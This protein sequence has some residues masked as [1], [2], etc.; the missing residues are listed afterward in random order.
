MPAFQPATAGIWSNCP[1][2]RD[3]AYAL[4][5]QGDS[6][7]PLYRDG[8]VLI[9][10]PAATIKRGDRVV[11]RD[12]YGRGDG[13]GAVA[14]FGGQARSQPRSTRAHPMRT[15]P[16]YDLELI[17]RI[18]WASQMC[19]D[20]RRDVG[21]RGR[22]G[23][24]HRVCRTHDA[25][26]TSL[27]RLASGE[28]FGLPAPTDLAPRRMKLEPLHDPA[29]PV[30]T[31]MVVLPQLDYG[32]LERGAPRDPLGPLLGAAATQE[33]GRLGRHHPLSPRCCRFR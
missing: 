32:T 15:V 2:R 1:R 18:V 31:A 12:R 17:A 20:G 3:G 7:L 30:A 8:D 19:V 5:V 13:Q 6:M 25:R 26:S 9:V 14:P 27:V 24:R 10:E 11:V 21:G 16:A 23:P 28:V 4:Q 29:R 22:V 33:N